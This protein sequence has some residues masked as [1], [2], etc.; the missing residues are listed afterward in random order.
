MSGYDL[1]SQPAAPGLGEHSR[2][3][4]EEAGLSVEE[5]AA[6]LRS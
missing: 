1:T 3:V 5:I 6:A 2:E 4:L